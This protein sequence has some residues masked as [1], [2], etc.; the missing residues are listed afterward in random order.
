MLFPRSDTGADNRIEG[1]KE[2]MV[3]ASQGW[4]KV[5]GPAGQDVIY[6]LVSPVALLLSNIRTGRSSA[7]ARNFATGFAVSVNS[8]RRSMRPRWR[9]RFDSEGSGRMHRRFGGGE[10]G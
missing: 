7:S 9:R 6:W 8:P 2:Y 5:S 10:A 3:P 4:F 1:S